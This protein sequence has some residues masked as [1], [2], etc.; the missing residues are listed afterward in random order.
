MKAVFLSALA[1][2]LSVLVPF[3]S[4]VH[5][6]SSDAVMVHV[7]NAPTATCHGTND[8][9]TYQWA[10]TPSSTNVEIRGPLT[11]ECA[12]DGFETATVTLEPIPDVGAEI[13][14]FGALGAAMLAQASGNLTY[15]SLVK[16][17][18]KP[19]QSAAPELHVEYERL[20]AEREAEEEWEE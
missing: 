10:K 9:G 12:Q 8:A 4:P 6:A 14:L 18:L 16:V 17:L 3:H 7:L 2:M 19:D 11:I 5:A 1:L 13:L 20:V 15:E